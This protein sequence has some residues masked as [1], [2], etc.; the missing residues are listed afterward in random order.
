MYKIL[1]SWLNVSRRYAC[2]KFNAVKL[3][4]REIPPIAYFKV[5]LE[6]ILLCYLDLYLK[7]LFQFESS[8]LLKKVFGVVLFFLKVLL[9]L[10]ILIFCY[11][12]IVWILS[13]RLDFN[14]NSG[15]LHSDKFQ[16]AKTNTIKTMFLVA[17]F[18]IIYLSN[19]EIYFLMTNLGF[20]AGWNSLYYKFTMVMTFFN[21]T[22]NPFIYLFK[23][24]D[25]HKALKKSLGCTNFNNVEESET[26]CSTI[27]TSVPE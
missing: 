6:Y 13:R 25:F 7:I 10:I 15:N 22:V 20:K 12:K 26:R 2:Q 11:G 19:D 18:F 27:T 23:Y 9:P 1:H 3:M 4:P 24:Q 17:L 8:P 5:H 14:T 21:C 16:L